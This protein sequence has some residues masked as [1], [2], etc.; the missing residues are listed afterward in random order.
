MLEL[1]FFDH[2]LE[3]GGNANWLN[4]ERS[5]TP[6]SGEGENKNSV[7]MHPLLLIIGSPCALAG[8]TMKWL[9]NSCGHFMPRCAGPVSCEAISMNPLCAI[10]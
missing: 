9:E 2:L 7:Q 10:V 4:L 3:G 1:A 6:P 8:I 5:P